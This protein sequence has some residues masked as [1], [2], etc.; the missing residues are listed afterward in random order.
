MSEIDE[1]NWLIIFHRSRWKGTIQWHFDRT[2]TFWFCSILFSYLLIRS[3]FVLLQFEH[4][5]LLFLYFDTTICTY[6]LKYSK[7]SSVPSLSRGVLSPVFAACSRRCV[8]RIHFNFPLPLCHSTNSSYTARGLRLLIT[9]F[10]IHHWT[11]C[12]IPI[13]SSRYSGP[14]A[15]FQ[16]RA[17]FSAFICLNRTPIIVV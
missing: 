8:I 1:W 14:I 7:L 5:Q 9:R 13:R 6:V 11:H 4:L 12:N 16:P 2:V 3:H 15:F 10:I 17:H